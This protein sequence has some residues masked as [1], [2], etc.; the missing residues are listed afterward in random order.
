MCLRL[1]SAN[2]AKNGVQLLLLSAAIVN[3]DSFPVFVVYR[4]VANPCK[5]VLSMIA[6]VATQLRDFDSTHSFVQQAAI[7]KHGDFSSSTSLNGLPRPTT[8]C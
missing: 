6:T 3:N 8:P 2:N 1:V 5:Y 4:R 7:E